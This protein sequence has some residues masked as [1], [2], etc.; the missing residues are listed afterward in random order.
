[1]KILAFDLDLNPIPVGLYTTTRLPFYY[2]SAI[3]DEEKSSIIY[4]VEHTVTTKIYSLFVF[5][6][7]WALSIAFF[8][9][10]CCCWFRKKMAETSMMEVGSALLFGLPALRQTLPTAPGMGLLSDVCGFFWC[11]ILV[12]FGSMLFKFTFELIRLTSLVLSLNINYLHHDYVD[13]LETEEESEVERIVS[14]QPM[15]GSTQRKKPLP[16]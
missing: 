4:R 15:L 16:I 12:S 11:M 8:Y 9:T 14:S 1:M 2:V 7:M 13:N 6:S 3:I 5:V 10:A